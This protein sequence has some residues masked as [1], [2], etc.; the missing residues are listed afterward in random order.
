MRASRSHVSRAPTGTATTIFAGACWRKRQH[1]RLHRRTGGQTIVD[2]NHRAI[3]DD[4]RLPVIT[5]RAIAT[6]QF[7]P[8]AHGDLLDERARNAEVA[9]QIFTQDFDASGRDRAHGELGMT[10][11]PELADQKDVE[12]HGELRGDFE[13]H[14]NAAARQ[15]Q[16]DD[17]GSVGVF[18]QLRCE[19]AAGV[20]TVAEL[21]GAS[22]ITRL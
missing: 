15:S 22:L 19:L 2:Q 14:G 18:G 5:I 3:A 9:N 13:R 7:Q 17:V 11:H 1:S 12:G 4:G 6:L 10:R 16:H 8:L 20:S 21:H